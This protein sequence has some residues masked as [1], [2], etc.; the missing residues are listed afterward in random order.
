MNIQYNLQIASFEIKDDLASYYFVMKLLLVLNLINA[1]LNIWNTRKE[2]FS[3]I[4]IIWIVVFVLSVVTL[5]LFMF[6]R[7]TATVVSVANIER[8]QEKSFLGRKRLSFVL[9]NG[10]SRHLIGLKSPS[11]INLVKLRCEELGITSG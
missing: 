10:K 2:G 1:V 6:K 7:T 8:L 5:Y 11:D 4:M 3:V 9:T